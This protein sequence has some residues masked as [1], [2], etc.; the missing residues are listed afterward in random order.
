MAKSSMVATA[1]PESQKYHANKDA[2][3]KDK[4]KGPR[5]VPIF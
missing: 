4:K 5:T 3:D 1:I 2:S